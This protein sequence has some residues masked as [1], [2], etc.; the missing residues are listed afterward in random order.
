MRIAVL[1]C[2]ATMDRSLATNPQA[3]SPFDR[4]RCD[5]RSPEI[6]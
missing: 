5:N 1:Q 4:E 6:H 3:S 2:G